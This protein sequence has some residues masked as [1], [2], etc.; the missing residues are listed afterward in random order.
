MAKVTQVKT[1]DF[2][3]CCKMFVIHGFGGGHGPFGESYENECIDPDVLDKELMKYENRYS[4]YTGLVATL[5]HPQQER[6]GHVFRKRSW[7]CVFANRGNKTNSRKL[8]M[9]FYDCSKQFK[10]E[11]KPTFKKAS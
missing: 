2:P 11:V 3:E 7:R 4:Q 5:S 8:Y 1:S 9:Y 6:I 10:K